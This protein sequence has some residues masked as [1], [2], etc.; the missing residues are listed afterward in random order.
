MSSSEGVDQFR[1][2]Y[3][4]SEWL[5]KRREGEGDQI[6]EL[7]EISGSATSQ[8]ATIESLSLAGFSSDVIDS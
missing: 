3:R 8:S 2:S 1:Q 4:R 5:V 7:V 6:T